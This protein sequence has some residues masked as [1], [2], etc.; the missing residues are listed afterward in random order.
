MGNTRCPRWHRCLQQP[1]AH[2]QPQVYFN[3]TQTILVLSAHNL[4]FFPC[5]T[6]PSPVAY[7][8]GAGI[9]SV[10]KEVDLSTSLSPVKNKTSQDPGC[11]RGVCTLQRAAGE[12]ARGWQSLPRLNPAVPWGGRG[13]AGRQGRSPKQKVL[14]KL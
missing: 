3:I 14:K 2:V 10:L 4:Y 7:L 5:I 12:E 9:S 13:G 8:A 1:T 11:L 6:I